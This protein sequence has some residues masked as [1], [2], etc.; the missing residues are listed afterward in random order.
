MEIAES[1]PCE[2]DYTFI[3]RMQSELYHQNTKSNSSI[4]NEHI[5][6]DITPGAAVHG[7]A[8]S[9]HHEPTSQNNACGCG[10]T[11]KFLYQ[12]PVA[13]NFPFYLNVVFH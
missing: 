13:S 5:L 3:N 12:D 7:V 11:I 6:R 10:Y 9:W 4:N 2:A 1:S 8:T